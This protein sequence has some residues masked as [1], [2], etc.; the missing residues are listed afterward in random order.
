MPASDAAGSGS[1]LRAPGG[2]PGTLPF[3]I[4]HPPCGSSRPSVGGRILAATAAP[5]APIAFLFLGETLLIPHLWPIAEALAEAA[6]DLPIDLWVSTSVHADMLGRWAASHPA[7]RLRRAPGFRDMPGLL[8]GTNPPLPSKMPM[9]ARLAPRLVGTRIAVCAEQ[10]SLWIP[11]LLPFHP[12][13]FVKTSHGVGSMSARDDRRRHA[14]ALT[15]VPSERERQTYLDR[16]MLPRRIVATGYVKSAFRQRT[17]AR[18]LFASEKPILLYTPHWQPHRSSWWTWGRQ[19]VEML[20]GLKGWNVIVA[21]HQRLIEKDRA[22]PAILGG[23]ADRP[24]VHVDW[25]SFAA[26]DGSYTRAADLYLGD[27]SSQIVEYLTRPRPALFLNPHKTDWRTSGEHD[28]WAC[29][30]VVDRIEDLPASLEKAR[31]RHP[32]YVEAQQDYAASSLG[33][34]PQLSPARCADYL[35]SL[36]QP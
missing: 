24:H 19:I 11:A 17:P 6:P 15:F 7:M 13:R 3:G 10:T 8:P 16:G 9:L 27:S 33:D 30:D 18:S 21:P 35:I 36:L 12:T 34:T 14:A 32:I 31:S 5:P 28:F 2:M 26:V 4:V 1:R 29:G 22:L 20:A 25:R 23:V